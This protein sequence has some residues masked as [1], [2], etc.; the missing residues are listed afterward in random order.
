VTEN[1]IWLK[2]SGKSLDK[3]RYKWLNK[4]QSKICVYREG[5][6]TDCEN[7]HVTGEYKET[8]VR[9]RE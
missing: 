3:V 5:I 4:V 8:F 1:E 7:P 9:W 2:I 6:V